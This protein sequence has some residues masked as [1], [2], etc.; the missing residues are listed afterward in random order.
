MSLRSMSLLVFAML[1]RPFAETAPPA[2]PKPAASAKPAATAADPAATTVA[3]PK[4][5]PAPVEFWVNSQSDEKY[6][7]NMIEAYK[8]KVDPAFEANVR[9][10]GFTE[11]PDKLAIAI[12]TGVNPPDI[13]QL[14]EIYFSLYL[15]GTVPF[16]DLTA[17]MEKSGLS[18]G[19]LPQR[20]GLFR[21]KDHVYG[22]PQSVSGVVLYYRDD[23]F[24]EIGVSPKSIDTWPKLEAVAKKLKTETRRLLVLDWSY[25]E[26]LMRQRGYELFDAAGNPLPDSAVAVSTLRKIKAWK[27][28]GIGLLPDRGSM[29]EPEFFNSYVQ[30]NGILAIVGADWYGLD[31]I[32]NMDPKHAG[33]WKAM[34]LPVWTDSLSRGQSPT[35]SFSGQGLVIFK[36]SKQQDRAWK[37]IEWVMKDVD[38]NVERYLEG[39]CFTP[40]RPAWTDLRFNRADPYFGGQTLAGLFMELAPKVP[41][42][43][44]SPYRAEFVQL[45]REKY[46]SSLMQG[47]TSPDSVYHLMKA[48]L[49]SKGGTKP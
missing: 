5:G 29:F 19:I 14:D 13:V 20:M 7:Q 40:Y 37:F 4:S 34:P 11:M 24:K 35:S 39:N 9:S 25:F 27:D 49:L 16:A 44:Q 3:K 42:V 10:Y 8:A 2:A 18:D 31:M 28:D 36:K 48:E 23:V 33:K 12:K 45:F 43:V 26:I 1:C 41:T 15:R 30:S 22:V 17:R 21:W 6:Y 38:A 47:T 46:W 32:Q